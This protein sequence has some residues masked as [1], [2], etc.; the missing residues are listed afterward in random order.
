[1]TRLLSDSPAGMAGA[2]GGLMLRGVPPVGAF[3]YRFCLGGSVHSRLMVA[4]D[5]GPHQAGRR[6][7]EW[8]LNICG[9]RGVLCQGGE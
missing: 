4:A 2:H 1:M 3:T 8:V 9:H 5:D 6:G 7:S